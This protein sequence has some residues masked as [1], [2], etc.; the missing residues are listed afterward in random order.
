[1]YYSDG[2]LAGM[3]RKT[4]LL[5]VCA[6]TLASCI[7]TIKT[8]DEDRIEWGIYKL[9][10]SI[11]DAGYTVY[12]EGE[13]RI[14][15]GVDPNSD[16]INS[17][18]AGAEGFGID[19]KNK[20]IRIDGFD[21]AGALYGCLTLGD[22]IRENKSIP[23][24]FELS[25]KPDMN[26]R[27]TCI[28]LMKLGTYNYPVTPEEFPF[29]YDKT[30]WLDYLNFLADNRFNYIAF[31][32]GHPFAYFVEMEKYPEAQDGMDPELIRR[33]HNMLKWLTQEGH[34]RN[35]R[36]MFEFY[37]IHT[38]VY[39]QKA[40][41]LPDEISEPTP[42][43]EDYTAYCIEKFVSEFPDVG[44]YVTPGEAL[45]PDFAPYWLNEVIFPAVERTGK[46]P[47]IMLREWG[48]DLIHARQI[49]DNYPNLYIERKYNVEMIA[50]TRIDP[51]NMEWA[52][53]NGNYVVNI[54]CVANL[55]PFRWN[56]PS[57]IQKCLASSA[58][59]GANGLHLY[60]R[61]A[62]R[63]PYVSDIDNKQLQW[64]RDALW[65][66]MW[67]RYAWK[68]NRESES[69]ELYWK[70]QLATQF[71]SEKASEHML[72]SF[73]AGADLLPALQRLFW[74]GN[75]NHTVVA[76]G[77]K[78]DQIENAA[79]IPFLS[80]ED[81][82]RIPEYLGSVGKGQDNRP[83]TPVRFLSNKLKE[84]QQASKEAQKGADA[85]TVNKEEAL[86]IVSDARAVEYLVQF[87]IYKLKAAQAKT[88]FKT[89][90]KSGHWK[91]LIKNL[92]LSKDVFRE[93]TRLTKTTYT[94]ISDVPAYTP[95]RLKKCPYHWSDVLPVFE[96]ELA[97]YEEELKFI[98]DPGFHQPAMPG[99]AGIWYGDPGLKNAKGPDPV[100]N[101]DLNWTDRFNERERRWSARWFGYLEAPVSGDVM[102]SV[103]ADQGVTLKLNN[104]SIIYWESG[105][106]EQSEIVPLKKGKYYLLDIIYDHKDGKEAYLNICWKWQNVFEPLGIEYL[107]YSIAQ[108]REMERTI[109]LKRQ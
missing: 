51:Q 45:N 104:N 96:K 89:S 83:N 34:K 70:D 42:L 66:K 60:P 13:F 6:A 23:E 18:A 50:D 7:Q 4:L 79:G 57:Y 98:N 53:L 88:K 52:Q 92:K 59:V 90:G 91:N 3:V 48:I 61:K 56:P 16:I 2:Y 106:G 19:I 9:Y 32:N 64:E 69:E 33:N 86:S 35:I 109:L 68:T 97:I 15:V 14:E 58:E 10:N 80:L 30:L 67:G 99:L 63:W 47:P 12:P 103:S 41:N 40:H 85:A 95:E 20:H 93:L 25:D 29:F 22:Y 31:W 37:N 62:W 73:E 87:Y 84:A 74:L 11:K 105:S 49:V 77:A 43:L 75:D 27:G 102:F 46:L 101:L 39:F 24:K 71:G 82:I 94:S 36:F 72:K 38:S 28:L 65:F 107:K 21:A 54:H 55:E 81:V 44:L 108:K 17:S 26:L 100:H 1:M 78:L 8:K 76:A 5:V